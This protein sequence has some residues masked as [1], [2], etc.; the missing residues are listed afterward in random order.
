MAIHAASF[1]KGFFGVTIAQGALAFTRRYDEQILNKSE[2][3]HSV[4]RVFR[5]QLG[6]LAS[7]FIPLFVF[8]DRNVSFS[9]FLKNHPSLVAVS[10]LEFLQNTEFFRSFLKENIGSRYLGTY[11]DK[12]ARKFYSVYSRIAG[13][14]EVKESNSTL[15]ALWNNALRP[16]LIEEVLYRGIIQQVFCRKLPQWLGGISTERMDHPI[17]KVMRIALS[18][19]LFGFG[20][21]YKHSN[22]SVYGNYK[23]TNLSA[24]CSITLRGLVGASFTET[25]GLLPAILN[26]YSHDLY[27]ALGK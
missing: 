20:H 3:V 19:F 23:N 18:V 21:V 6:A 5:R 17:A 27:C 25:M 15:R 10:A 24:V 16:A 14:F 7:I 13:K 1:V 26:H 9:M 4:V 2:S 22:Y 11:A 8:K 12:M